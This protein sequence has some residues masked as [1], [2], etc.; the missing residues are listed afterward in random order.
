MTHYLNKKEAE[1]GEKLLKN[2]YVIS[3][4]KDL[5]HLNYIRNLI[6][7]KSSKILKISKPKDKDFENFLNNIHKKLS[8]KNLNKFRLELIKYISDD[9]DFKRNYFYSARDLLFPLVGNELAMQNSVGLSIQFPK[10]KSS[11]LP[12]HSD[13]WAGNSPFEV[14]VWI[15]LVNCF[16]TKS[17]YILKSSKSKKIN[18]KFIRSKSNLDFYKSI[19]DDVEFIKINFGEVLIFNQNLPHGNITNQVN[20]TRWSMNCRFKSLYSPY[21]DKKLGE[22]FHPITL[23][24]AS[25]IGMQFES[26]KTDD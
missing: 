4:Q 23:R 3:K 21:S 20:E 16:S 5:T 17:M 13:S 8:V 19:K 14:V 12:T 1:L 9:K 22:Y 2:G 25:K 6:V 10:D 7:E 24:V 18:D 11:L 26:P 15:P